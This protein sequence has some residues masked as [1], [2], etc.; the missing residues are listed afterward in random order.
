MNEVT[1]ADV[2]E[3]AGVSIATASRALSG[4]RPVSET[5][6][7]LVEKA[8]RELGYRHNPLAGALR[9]QRSGAI[10]VLLPRFSAGFLST[11]VEAI[12]TALEDQRRTLTLRY[13]EQD[14]DSALAG[15]QSLRDR[16]VD[17]IIVCAP[18]SNVAVAIT[19]AASSLPLVLVGR[20]HESVA[21]DSVGL[22]DERAVTLMVEHLRPR[23]QRLLTV[24][25][26]ETATADQRRRAAL[27]I[28]ARAQ[29]LAVE[30]LPAVPANLEGGIRAAEQLGPDTT[31]TTPDA[32][33]PTI[34]CAN[35]DV[36]LGVVTVARMR[37]FA[38]P[39]ALQVASMMDVSFADTPDRTIT[40]LRHPWP[41]M[42]SEAARLLGE[43]LRADEPRTTG[44]RIVLPPRLLAGSST[45]V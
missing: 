20:Y 15:V 40:T 41:Q 32:L 18:S 3:R 33:P 29:G 24:G 11:V 21:C 4:S 45:R 13:F 35:D 43:S 30:H 37:A 8:V 16:R 19:E 5:N 39:D 14:R 27:E 22:D 34:V 42:G 6:M 17:G 28:T 9:T 26:D 7:K 10:G 25:F 23:T 12:S 31:R 44:R 36:A 2:A 38:V 1:L